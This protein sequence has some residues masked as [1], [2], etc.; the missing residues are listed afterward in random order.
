MEQ[1][2][3]YQKELEK[4]ISNIGADKK[5]SL[6]LHA[7]CG[8][9]SSYVIEY[10]SG[11]FDITVFYYNPN[12]YPPAEY[13]RRLSELKNFL[14]RFP[15]A[16]Q[17]KVKLVEAPYNPQ[18]FYDAVDVAGNPELKTEPERGERCRRCYLLRM[19]KSFDYARENGFDYFTTTLSISPYK[20]TEK[21]NTIGHTF[22]SVN[23]THY[24]PADFKKKSGFL[25]STQ[26]SR[27]YGLYRQD[28]CGCVFSMEN[29]GNKTPA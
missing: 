4:I 11:I 7:C 28:Y 16:I 27:E 29:S 8:P 3:N 1:K 19:Q 20:D 18:E 15:P 21:I 12:I 10:L 24:L 9:C 5:P 25:R 6:L 13:E 23:K 22:V 26:L 14:P 17:N 2:I